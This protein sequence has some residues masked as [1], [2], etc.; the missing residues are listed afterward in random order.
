MKNIITPA[1]ICLI[2]ILGLVQPVSAVSVNI[3]DG[4][5]EQAI[6]EQLP[7]PILAN[8]PLEDTHLQTLV[9]LE[10][11]NR[12]VANLTGLEH[13]K[14]LR[15][16]LFSRNSI[17]DLGPLSAL[18]N[19]EHLAGRHN[20]VSNLAPLTGLTNLLSLD[21]HDNPIDDI[22]ALQALVNLDSIDLS[23]TSISDLSPLAG[24]TVLRS[25]YVDYCSVSDLTPLQ[26]L[27]SL[28]FLSAWGNQIDNINALNGG[29]PALVE[30]RLVSNAI[31]DVSPALGHPSLQHLF[32]DENFLDTSAGSS[33]LNDLNQLETELTTLTYFRQ[34]GLK[35]LSPPGPVPTFPVFQYLNPVPEGGSLRGVIKGDTGRFIAAGSSGHALI[36]DDDGATWQEG[37]FIGLEWLNAIAFDRGVFTAVGRSGIFQS[38]DN[39]DSWFNA[40]VPNSGSLQ[41]VFAVDL[42][43]VFAA[44]GKIV[45]VGEGGIIFVFDGSWQSFRWTPD[46]WEYTFHS[47]YYANGVWLAG[48]ERGEVYRPLVPSDPTTPWMPQPITYNDPN[49]PQQHRIAGFAHDGAGT[50]ITVG[51]YGPSFASQDDGET[52]VQMGFLDLYSQD[53]VWDGTNFIVAGHGGNNKLARST[54]GVDWDTSFANELPFEIGGDLNDIAHGSLVAVGEGRQIVRSPDGI[55]WENVGSK[56][57]FERLIQIRFLNGFFIAVGTRGHIYVSD[58]GENWERSFAHPVMWYVFA[59]YGKGVFIIGDGGRN[60]YVSNDLFHWSSYHIFW[61]PDRWPR[62]IGFG[63]GLFV[64][65]GSSGMIFTSPDGEAWTDRSVLTSNEFKSVA[66]GAGRFVAVGQNNTT[67]TS[68]DGINWESLDLEFPSWIN[69]VHYS[70]TKGEFVVV[71]SELAKR[72]PDGLSWSEINTQNFDSDW[73]RVTEGD[74][75]WLLSTESQGIYSTDLVNWAEFEVNANG[76]RITTVAMGEN[77]I[78]FGGGGGALLVSQFG[79]PEFVVDYDSSLLSLVGE[80]VVVS[81][82][83]I[84]GQGAIY[85]WFK[86]GAPVA[87]GNT[88]QLALDNAQVSDSGF[89][90]LEVT[91][92]FGN[93]ISN[94]VELEVL[95][96]IVVNIPDPFLEAEIRDDLG[97]LSGD[98]LVSDMLL[99]D[100][101]GTPSNESVTDLTGLE[102]ARNLTSLNIPRGDYADLSPLEKLSRLKTLLLSRNPI[103]DISALQPL[104]NLEHLELWGTSISDLSPLAGMTALRSLNVDY[105]NNVSD[106]TPLQNLANLES[107]SAWGNQ[108]GNIN[109]LNGGFPALVRLLLGSNAI[110]DVSP[111]LGH[112]TL[113]LLLIDENFLDTSAGSSD[114]ND[115]N[116]LETELTT[117]TYFRQ[118]GLKSL[119]PP[120]PVPTFPVFQ[121]LNPVPEGGSLRG[122]IKGDTGRYIAVGS[123]GHALFSDDDGATWQEGPFIGSQHLN[124]I[125]FDRGV[126][127]AVG[128]SGVFQSTDNG[129]SWFNANV[130]DSVSPYDSFAADLNDVFAA[131]GKIVTVGGGGKIFVFDG[132]WQSF[133]W[134]PDEWE[135]SFHSVYYANGVWLAGNALGEIYRPTVPSDPTTPWMPQPIT[136][137]DPNNPQ[138]HQFT[139]F[140]YDGAGTFMAVDDGGNSF[141]SQNDGENWI[142]MGNAGIGG[143]NIVWDGANFVVAGGGNN[144]LARSPDGVDWDSSFANE[145]LF[146]IGGT[147]NDIALGP[148][149]AVGQGRQIVRS[150]DGIN[151][152]N[153]GSKN[154]FVELMQIRYLNGFFVAL[155][156]EGYIYISD[157]GENWERS[158]V[159]LGTRFEDVAYGNGVF[160]IVDPGYT[161]SVSD[162]L[163]HWSSSYIFWGPDRR[164]SNIGFGNGLFVL[165]G[166]SGMIFTSPDGETWTDRS[167]QTSNDFQSVAFG[168]GRFVAVGQNNTTYTST[169]GINWDSLDLE[170]PSWI[171]DIYYSE[172]KGEFVVVGSELAKRSSN[173]L[174]WSEINTQIFDAD[175]D[176]VTEG[177]GV[178]LLNSDRQAIYS[179]D[180]VNWAEFE[181]NANGERITT[182]AMGENHIVFGGEGG[183]LLVSQ[184]GAPEFVVDYDSSLLSLVGEDVVVSVGAI[185]GQG[186]T[187]QW[188]KDGAPVPGGNTQNFQITNAASSDSGIYHV[189]VTNGFGSEIS[190]TVEL[191]VVANSAVNIPDPVLEAEIRDDLGI[192]SGDIL[193]SDMLLL[194]DISTPFNEQVTDLIGLEYARK[195]TRFDIQNGAFS[196]LSPLEKLSELTNLAI[197]NNLDIVDLTPLAGLPKVRSLNLGG[198][199]SLSDLSPLAGMT[200]L[201]TLKV[202]ECS[203][204]DLSPIAGLTKLRDLSIG[205]NRTS[206]LTPLQNLVN[207][208]FLSAWRCG[209]DDLSPL[210]G[211]TLLKHVDLDDNDLPSIDPLASL[212]NLQFLRAGGNQIESIS[213]L[214]GG[215]PAI[216]ELRL[217]SNAIDDVSPALGHPS[218]DRLFL[219]EN[220]LDTGAGSSDLYDLNQLETELSTL[221]YF[222]QRGLKTLSP[223]GPVPTFPAFQYLNPVPEGGSLQGV[224][225]GDTGRFIAVGSS[226]HAL[227]SD[228]DGATWRKGPFIGS[229]ELNAIA[230]ERGVFTAVGHPWDNGIGI[231]QSTDNGDSWFKAPAPITWTHLH[232]VFAANGKIVAVGGDGGLLV[233]DGSWQFF[234]W[235]PEEWEYTFRSV[236][237]A[238]GVWLA[239]NELGE[240]YRPTVPSDPTTQWTPQSIA[241]NDPNNPP[242]HRFTGFAYDGAGTFMAVDIDGYSFVSQDDG[243]TWIQMGHV[244][245]NINIQDIVWD[246]ANFV[247][248]CNGENNKIAR[249]TDGVDWDS[250]FANEL[251]FL[252]EGG[253]NDIALG[254]LVAVGEGRQI[255]RSPDGINWQDVGSKNAFRSFDQI[256]YLNGFFVAIGSGRI[257]VSDDGENW[258]LSLANRWDPFYSCVPVTY[259]N[260]VFV[261]AESGNTISVSDDLLHWSTSFTALEPH[262]EPQAIAFGNGLFVLV[263]KYGMIFTSRD[264]ETWTDRSVLTSNDFRSVAFGAGRFVVVGQNN[265]TYTS[266]DGINWNSLDLKF[267]SC[268]VDIHFSETKGEFVA[269]GSDLAKR[270]PNGLSWSDIDTKNYGRDWSCVAEGDG[271]WLLLNS[272]MRSFYST[273]LVNWADFEL[274]ANGEG[275]ATIAMG[276]NH[277]V[278]GGSGGSLLVSQ[279]GAPEFVVEYDST[280]LSLLGEDVVVSVGAIGGHGATY[281]WFKD[282]A[283]VAGGNTQNLQITH[284]ASSNAGIYHV[285]VTNRLGSEI[286]N[287]VELEVVANIAVNIPDPVLEAEIRSDLG[288]LSGDILVSDM[289]LLDNVGTSSNESVTN[290]TGLEYARN[291][292][293]LSIMSSVFADLSPLEKLTKLEN[294]SITDNPNIVNLTPIAGLANV[295][296]LDLSGNRGLSDLSPLAGMTVLRSLNLDF[297]SVS[298]LTPL[299]NLVNLEY[300]SAWG[301]Q[302]GNINSLNG[303]F[304]ALV[305]LLL[306]SNAIDDV[307]PALGHPTLDL[308]LIDENFLDTSAGSS[309]LNDLNQLETELTT[310]TY[311]R[312]RGLKSLSPPGPVPTFPVFQYLNPVP[313]GGS[314]RGVIKGYTGRY[315]AVGSSGHALFS[316]DDGATWQEGPFIG[317]GHLNAIAFDRGVFTAVG[318]AGIF[319]STDNGNSWFTA[320]VPDRV[321]PHDA[322]AADLSDVF[323]ADGKIVAVGGSGNI[324][325]FDG[326]WQSFRWTPDEWEY[327]F[328]SVYYANGVWLAG[329]ALGEIYRPLVPSDPTTQWLPQSITYNDPNHP[330]QHRIAGFAYNGAG[331]FMAVD[332]GGNS[333]ASQNDGENWIQMGN[334]GIG[335][336][337][338]V[339]DGANFVVAGGGNNNLARSPDGVDWDSSFAN[340]LLFQIGGTLNDIALGPLVAVGQGRQ[341]VRSPDGIN[342]ENVGS[343]NVFVELMQ[344]RYLNGFFVALGEE[345]Y[346]Y[347]SDDGENWER[348]FVWLGTRF[349]DV[350]YGNGVFVIVDPGY[351]ISVSDDLF[352]WSSS[353]IFWGPDRRPSN[354]GFGNGLF[355]LVGS[356]GMIFTSPDGE[357]WTDRS[358]QTSNDFQSVAFG[359]GRFVAVGQNNT[360]Y[361]ST[362]GINWDSLDLEFPSWINDIYYS[363]TKG[364]FVVV[365]SEL[366][367]R[368][369]NGLSWSE[370]NTQIFDADWD[371]VTEGDG[372]WLLNSDRQAIYSTDLVNWAEFEVNANGE[373]ITT[374]AMGENHIV[375]GGEGGSLLVSQFGAPEFVVDYKSSLLYFAGKDVVLSVGGI[376]GQGAR[377]QWFKDGAPVAGGNTQQLVLNNAQVSDSGLYHLEVTNGFGNGISNTVKLEVIANLVVNV[378]DP[379]LEAE[380]RDD[381]GILSGDILHS[382]M[383]LLDDVSTPSNEQVADLTGL[384]YAWNLTR[385]SIQNGVFA[386]LSPL[387]KLSKLTDLS[388]T[389]NPI[390]ADL[391]PL[392]GLPNVR[393]LNL[394]GNRG[395]SDLSPI[396]GYNNLISLSL[397]GTAVDSIDFLA[398]PGFAGLET[399]NLSNTL[400]GDLSP[401]AS[402]TGLRNLH[403]ENL[404]LND[405]DLAFLGNGNFNQLRHIPMSGNNITDF[406]FLSAMHGLLGLT[407]NFHNLDVVSLQN[408]VDAIKDHRNFYWLALGDGT[409]TDITPLSGLSQITSLYT[410]YLTDNHIEDVSP[411]AGL[412]SVQSILVQ[413]NNISDI[414][415]LLG[416]TSLNN[417]AIRFNHLD[418]DV[419]DDDRADIDALIGN[420]ARVAFE[421]QRLPNLSVADDLKDALEPVWENETSTLPDSLGFVESPQGLSIVLDA[422]S[423]GDSVGR[424]YRV[425]APLDADWQ[426]NVTIT[427]PSLEI[428]LPS[429]AGIPNLE[430]ALMGL[431]VRNGS[432]AS[433]SLSLM[434]GF[435]SSATSTYGIENSRIVRVQAF[436]DGLMHMQNRQGPHS[437]ARVR[438]VTLA[439]LWDASEGFLYAFSMQGSHLNWPAKNIDAS[440]LW[441]MQAGDHFE[442]ALSGFMDTD[443]AVNPGDIFACNFET[444]SLIASILDHPESQ[445][446]A[447]GATPTLEVA[448]LGGNLSYEWYEG[449]SGDESSGMLGTDA[450]FTTS[451]LG[452]STSFWVKVINDVSAANSD[453]AFITVISGPFVEITIDE[454]PEGGAF[455]AGE[456]VEL[457]VEAESDGPLTYQWYQGDSG[458]TT[459]PLEGETDSELELENLLQGGSYWVRVSN[460]IYFVDSNAAVVALEFEEIEI[461]EH[462][463]GG[464][465]KPG[466][467]VTLTVEVDDD[468]ELG[469]LNYQWYNGESGDVS[470]P[471]DGETQAELTLKDLQSEGSYWVR[472]SNEVGFVDSETAMVA[473]APIGD[474]VVDPDD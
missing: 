344:I 325:V 303:G 222:R 220:F 350:A 385:L 423:N 44:D 321:S 77:H 363:E 119:S 83:G 18:T 428:G 105:S 419:G 265:T 185:G 42:Y 88:Q 199:R 247:V 14:N 202:D 147:L 410:I 206:D 284:V 309:D 229:G 332:D 382:D 327:S 155:G 280:L 121:Y 181:V 253:L 425:S 472:V 100:D 439:L 293:D 107:L 65:V 7:T 415:P 190:N 166:S 416:M 267:P 351:T 273:D 349:E 259:G 116:Q 368:S 237:Y 74:G 230:F 343:K 275:I 82:G 326:S 329:N 249:S 151:W 46:E 217:D 52:W 397:S 36:S 62:D 289:L 436:I 445:I 173:G 281:Q 28:E 322:F 458:D 257:Y 196:D 274:N 187:Y 78:V 94:T 223:S 409:L 213:S 374:V 312:Q 12:N 319:Q 101:V 13:A 159:W 143:P 201:M 186:A 24:M 448:A 288:I 276:E 352:H 232:D 299:Q 323:A 234:Q 345:G 412:E 145:L 403:I 474:L 310:L 118:R 459:H 461:E 49:N 59:T 130:P 395:I 348:S 193:V 377:Y 152:E 209:I 278:F 139:G 150:P 279:F 194:D 32:I 228:N 248:V 341:I 241:Y 104:V 17:S 235:T 437:K 361:T 203:V 384:E 244:G 367:K 218:L 298:E 392:A 73:R 457:S 112:P 27:A 286:S 353:Y 161:I 454:Q 133:Q 43:D 80:D 224:I 292:T 240:I 58:D 469:T 160:V 16:F 208:E 163:F 212:P 5:L 25:L 283:P 342:W 379:V 418:I 324:F 427:T 75:V 242:R 446:V 407:Y 297:C 205:G 64:L 426:I 455:D 447:L 87:G 89:Y 313:E 4:N 171:N 404:N 245:E 338:I 137:N 420:G 473:L 15:S 366:A 120:G 316:D 421:P 179:T 154:V 134:T 9:Y 287:T 362:D 431:T 468:D 128:Y 264:G 435:Q 365:G 460:D 413:N 111:A 357:T 411:L 37:P 144:N 465:F 149:V 251:P 126:F 262:N 131:D 96:N 215:F 396:F 221:T 440:F 470:N 333:F 19:L 238:N 1:T 467:S 61:G 195:L 93:E 103:R 430:Q 441:G 48:N 417:L 2:A 177:D 183:S 127:S 30:L 45:A 358:V 306:G 21:L 258:D 320:S 393:Y 422:D 336:P 70:E 269:V 136:Y 76:E 135:Y 192:L 464:V 184:F 370:I 369:S 72:S 71:G 330:Q 178:W 285:E 405:A 22:A 408:L 176:R 380:I 182:V 158:F 271:V 463:S 106:L 148:L 452:A 20:S 398:G 198:N 318:N 57:V 375:F 197:T 169:D 204:T 40:T 81:V 67:Y 311:F 307:S 356:S 156:E 266:T 402:L 113:D 157:D 373:R 47:V 68:A 115:L 51:H 272:G 277:I 92:G 33:D 296:N 153:V 390:I 414:S 246:G 429:R 261:I 11:E 108:I 263:G 26:N 314:L 125:A 371:R 66:F 434:T 98:I 214:N 35:S 138:Q 466:S 53:I 376:G 207:L 84:G 387:E 243:E 438:E 372:V 189:E 462:P 305:R 233:Y 331:T 109:S 302:I 308:L 54:D 85:Q 394:G 339:W 354:I 432:D 34:R 225:K 210:G 260:G 216:I 236:Y 141:A 442:I 335:G 110:D 386:D 444:S 300:L 270:S 164:P 315:I 291:L 191:E 334:A 91:N 355:V 99:L 31:D 226:G 450:T 294:L 69:D 378:P 389:N 337:N 268:I 211:L 256:R 231:N 453:A 102:Y 255:L 471:L 359:A 172:T 41:D 346:I 400:V 381:L 122:V 50:F 95:E 117:L 60:I 167:V 162:D 424:D 90:H 200:A 252:T 406:G 295:V 449:L 383:L 290:L 86:D 123:S 142:Q 451:P 124:A 8:V 175:W 282:G 360:T 388:I 328:R 140:A 55:N 146:Q 168:A 79:A 97:I 391:T 347:I 227:I 443:A 317:S 340:E 433:D 29:F 304:P 219:N 301:N 39:G 364:E 401:I 170:F 188:F 399:L 254:P 56:N 250:S 174:S 180:L 239:G 23:G 132:S 6:R 10:I 165:V 3:P 456:D 63:N 129:D 38:T 114:L